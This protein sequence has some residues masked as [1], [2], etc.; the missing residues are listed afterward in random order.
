MLR[1]ALTP[2]LFLGAISGAEAQESPK[3]GPIAATRVQTTSAESTLALASASLKKQSGID[4]DIAGADAAA[5]VEPIPATD[6]WLAVE[7]LAKQTGS[8]IAPVAGKVRFTKGAPGPSSVDGPFRVSVKQVT[9]KR[10]FDT[11]TSAYAVQLEVTWEPRFPVYMIDDVP[12]IGAATAGGKPLKALTG[13]GRVPTVGFRQLSAVRLEGIARTASTIDVL[14][15]TFS[16]VAAEKLLAVEFKDL[17]ADKSVSQTKDGVTVT[18]QPIKRSGKLT[19]FDITME[20]PPSHPEFESFELWASANKLKLY[21]PSAA[22]G[23]EPTDYSISEAG[24]R[25]AATYTYEAPAG[26]PAP[27]ADLKGWRAVYETSGPMV[28][29]TVKFELKGIALP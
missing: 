24:R 15:G 13:G 5:K 28:V 1:F 27:L 6:F 7:S 4:F 29:Q 2:F 23:F 8:R 9:A 21:P 18:L 11:D 20:Y 14:S 19:I 3:L 16:V 12:K 22:K 25:I 10:D 17:T 26:K